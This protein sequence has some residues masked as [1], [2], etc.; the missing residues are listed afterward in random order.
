MRKSIQFHAVCLMAAFSLVSCAGSMEPMHVSYPPY[1]G[2]KNIIICLDGTSNDWQTRTNVRRLYE[3]ISNQD[4]PDIVV[5]YDEG[6]DSNSQHW[7]GSAL[8]TGFGANVRQAY[9]F[10]AQQYNPGDKIY[11]FGFSRGAATARSLSGMIRYVGLLDQSAF[12]N[13][14]A[15][16]RG[17]ESFAADRIIP[18][19]KIG[20]DPVHEAYDTYIANIDKKKFDKLHAA[21]KSRYKK[22]HEVRVTVVGV[23]DTV[24]ALGIPRLST[25]EPVKIEPHHRIELQD[26]IDYAFQALSIDEK[27]VS[28]RPVLWDPSA[29][30][31]DQVLEQ[32][33]FSG[34]HSDIGGG[35]GDS[36]EL[37]GLTLNWM[38]RKLEGTKNYNLLPRGYTV[39][40]NSKGRIH[41]S[42]VKL[43][44]IAKPEVRPDLKCD[45]RTNTIHK[46]VV[47]RIAVD[48]H[49]TVEQVKDQVAIDVKAH[50]PYGLEKCF[51]IDT[52]EVEP[53]TRGNAM[54]TAG[55]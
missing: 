36:K 47:D 19:D 30:K 5:Y 11:L 12:A 55:K 16:V 4:R 2:Q 53:G 50:Y 3:I 35:Y 52:T 1:T 21:L 43:F 45:P 51:A 27:R 6:V 13:E 17:P 10:L 46:S 32:V 28:F 25:G 23:W 31:G 42:F 14:D 29:K 9:R 37:A 39:Y 44:K 15:V 8:G 49:Y 38:L 7:L 26:N 41:N 20:N 34:V 22:I 24:E 40:A 18:D 33:W 48:S 54:Q